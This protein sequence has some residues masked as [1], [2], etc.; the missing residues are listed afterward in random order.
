MVELADIEAAAARLGDVVVRTPLI[1]SPV[2]D[3]QVG[4][5]E[6]QNAR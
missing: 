1:S 4:A 3:E 2:L 5:D 6:G